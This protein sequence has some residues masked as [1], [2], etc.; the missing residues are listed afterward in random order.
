VGTKA[1][2]PGPARRRR[3]GLAFD[4]ADRVPEDVGG[5]LLRQL[6]PEPEHDHCPLAVRQAQQCPGQAIPVGDNII[7]RGWQF[8]RVPGHQLLPLLLAAAVP[9]GVSG[10]VD[11][12]APGVGERVSEPRPAQ[13]HP[14]QR[15]LSRVLGPAA[16]TAQRERQPHQAIAVDLH[17]LLER[18]T[19]PITAPAVT[20][21]LSVQ[22]GE[23]SRLPPFFTVPVLTHLGRP[24]P[25][26]AAPQRM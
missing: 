18:L 12:R 7:D 15:L 14:G 3:L 5:L 26:R 24:G 2:S 19:I 25:A 23:V 9:P 13:V 10:R 8:G 16:I 4:S 20:W 21:M 1:S 22:G 6:V 11:N 17:E